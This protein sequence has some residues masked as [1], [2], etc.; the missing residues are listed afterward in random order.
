MSN[1][2]SE[3]EKN[4]IPITIKSRIS[5]YFQESTS[6]FRY[7]YVSYNYTDTSVHQNINKYVE[8]NDIKI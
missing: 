3:N 8:K 6:L 1:I 7:T 4:Y 2:N 5:L